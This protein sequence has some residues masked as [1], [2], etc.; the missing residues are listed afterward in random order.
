MYLDL[1]EHEALAFS[2][3]LAASLGRPLPWLTAGVL[4]YGNDDS[5]ADRGQEMLYLT[6]AVSPCCP[7][8]NSCLVKREKY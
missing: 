5:T 3:L 6:L 2:F 7:V 8:R 4:A 1:F